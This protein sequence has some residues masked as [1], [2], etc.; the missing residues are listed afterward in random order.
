M[1]FVASAQYLVKQSVLYMN[2]HVMNMYSV[3]VGAI[4]KAM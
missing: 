1:C 4:A 2:C 3:L